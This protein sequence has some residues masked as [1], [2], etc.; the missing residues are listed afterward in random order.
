METGCFYVVRA[1]ILQAKD[2]GSGVEFCKKFYEEWIS[3]GSRGIAIV[4][5][6]TRKYL[7]NRLRTLDCVL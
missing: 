6:V 7:V 2:K 4:G 3:A 1:E 5:A